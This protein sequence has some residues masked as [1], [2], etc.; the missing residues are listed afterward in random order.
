[1]G[2]GVA[3]DKDD[4]RGIAAQL[5]DTLKEMREDGTVRETIGKYLPDAERFVGGSD[6]K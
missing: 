2:L 5:N 1:M 3:F 4:D 6:E